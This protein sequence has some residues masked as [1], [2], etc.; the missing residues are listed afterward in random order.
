MKISRY[1]VREVFEEGTKYG[2]RQIA[3]EE[4]IQV[5]SFIQKVLSYN[6]GGELKITKRKYDN[7]ICSRSEIFF[8]NTFIQHIPLPFSIKGSYYGKTILTSFLKL[9][10]GHGEIPIIYA[11]PSLWR[12]ISRKIREKSRLQ[13]IVFTYGSQNI[14]SSYVD[15]P[16]TAF[17]IPFSEALQL[18]E[19]YLYVS[20][21]CF[22]T[23]S[24]TNEIIYKI[25]GGKENELIKIYTSYISLP[26]S[27]SAYKWGG[28]AA[29]LEI[30]R[31]LSTMSELHSPVEFVFTNFLRPKLNR[32]DNL[33]IFIEGLGSPVGE[34]KLLANVNN[35]HLK[36]I[37]KNI[38]GIKLVFNPKVPDNVL[39]IKDSPYPFKGTTDDSFDKISLESLIEKIESIYSLL[40]AIVRRENI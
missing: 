38:K 10:V 35:K 14:Y 23:E 24:Y 6:R 39:I 26:Y 28:V 17:S 5:A 19:K 11:P 8:G 40:L 13:V 1:F 2:H 21:E 37:L 30:A 36:K 4:A 3:S 27:Q 29:S 20:L 32:D 22:T 16:V 15:S 25:Y 12:K 34:I 18:N 31:L 9:N 33:S 7:W